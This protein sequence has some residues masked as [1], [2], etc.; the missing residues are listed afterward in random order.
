MLSKAPKITCIKGTGDAK[1]QDNS[2]GK[3]KSLVWKSRSTQL[4]YGML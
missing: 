2:E 3:V 1:Q 4:D